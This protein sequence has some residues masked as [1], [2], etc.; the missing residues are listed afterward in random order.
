MKCKDLSHVHIS[1]DDRICL[2]CERERLN[3][4]EERVK[5]LEENL[6]ADAQYSL[7]SKE[8]A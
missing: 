2:Y 3:K 7:P 4:L 1:S 6:K 5:S 8:G